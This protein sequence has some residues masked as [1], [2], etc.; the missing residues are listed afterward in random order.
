MSGPYLGEGRVGHARVD[1]VRNSFRYPTFFLFFRTEQDKEVKSIL[2]KK[3]RGLF[4][5]EEKDYLTGESGSLDSNARKFIAE[6][7]QY[8]PDEIWL[9]TMPRMFNYAFNPVSFWLCLKNNQL[10]AVLCEVNNTFGE[11]HMYWVK[12]D[13]YSALEGEWVTSEKVFHVS[14]FLPV[15]GSYKFKFS[16]QNEKFRADIIYL[17]LQGKPQLTTYVDGGL[18]SLEAQKAWQVLRKYGWMTVFVVVRIHLQA[19]KLWLKRMPYF[20]KPSPPE[21]FVT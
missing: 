12:K 8:Q 14:P 2:Q 15:E 19:V 1:K 11:R 9:Q 13:G 6:N 21:K 20:S 17:D 10:E 4:R 7:F 3:Y 18:T 16:F 5:F